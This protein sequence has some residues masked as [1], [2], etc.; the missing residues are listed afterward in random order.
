MESD[1]IILTSKARCRDCYRC[2]RACPVKAIK[3]KGGQAYV[4]ESRCVLCGT[5]VRECPQKAK[6]IRSDTE[7]AAG[8]IK[9]GFYTAVS[10]APSFAAIYSDWRLK[11]IVSALRRLVFNYIA[12]TAIG[13][14][15]TAELTAALC[16][17]RNKTLI[18]SA[19]P[20]VVN[21]I[22]KYR[23]EMIP[24]LAGVVS[25]MIA[26]A[27]AIIAKLSKEKKREEYKIIF[28]GPCAAKKKEAEREEFAGFIDAAITFDELDEWLE[29]ENINLN[30][31]E[32]SDF[33]EISPNRARLFPLE[34]GLI[35]TAA[36][37]TDMLDSEILAIS[38]FDEIENALEVLNSNSGLDSKIKIIEPLFCVKGCINGPGAVLTEKSG[39][40]GRKNSIIEYYGSGAARK[41]KIKV[42]PADFKA[43]YRH[44]KIEDPQDISEED[45]KSVLEK[46]G[47]LNIEDELNCGACGYNS[48]RDKAVAV[49][50]G[51][52]ELEMCMPYMRK[53]AERRTDRIIETSPNGIIILDEKLHI[54]SM[55]GAFKKMFMC[56]EVVIGKRISYI[57]DPANFE[58]LSTRG[59]AKIE[60]I[61]KYPSY[62]LICHEILYALSDEK[63]YV[64]IFVDITNLEINQKRLDE[65]KSKTVCQA[66]ELL[67]H[68]I[69]MAQQM[70]K[71][72][73]EYTARGEE[74]VKN[75]MKVS[76]PDNPPADRN[77]YKK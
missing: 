17:E 3:M 16:G 44:F 31:C 77:I 20:A 12:E 49:I 61:E 52:A 75:L 46:T 57:I 56:S 15:I 47:K 39:I 60:T 19:C 53:M 74:L 70:A 18:A 23:Q 32:E 38:G 26:H 1:K 5:C 50:R 10:L 42:S 13:A 63:Q 37:E 35:K 36:L 25:P 76:E 66:S 14:Q 72:L 48:C 68:Q 4:E 73:G 8:Y 7:R 27:K 69:N 67:E 29:R 33:D 41:N 28:I 64:G 6:S 34:G 11:R 58:K 45:I 59:G 24:A 40:F 62:N 2:L 51:M 30:E 65:I 21:Y 71:F 9:D 54:I 43:S 55:N 22:E